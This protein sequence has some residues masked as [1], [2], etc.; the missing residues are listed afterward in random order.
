[1][2][3]I[4]FNNILPLVIVC[5]L[6]V[7]GLSNG[8]LP[9]KDP[10]GI[11]GERVKNF[12]TNIRFEESSEL[13]GINH[14][15]EIYDPAVDFEQL[16]PYHANSAGVAV[17]DIDN[18]GFQDIFF[19]TMKN[20]KSNYLYKNIK[21]RSFIDVTKESGLFIDTND[22]GA[23]T[24]AVFFDY[25]NDSCQDLFIARI[26]CHSLYRGNC[27]GQFSDVSEKT[28]VAKYC[29]FAVGVNLV[30]Y[31]NDG[32]TDLYIPN[33]NGGE[34]KIAR[35][36]YRLITETSN[37]QDGGGENIL[38]ENQGVKGFVDVAKERGVADPGLS[39]ASGWSDF[40]KDGKADLYVADDFSRDQF[41]IGEEESNDFKNISSYIFKPEIRSRGSMTV[42]IGDIDNDLRPDVFTTNITRVGYD[43]GLNYMWLNKKKGKHNMIL[44]NQA[45]RLQLSKCGWGWGARFIDADLDGRLE[46]VVNNGFWDDGPKPYWY[47][48]NTWLSL[49][50]FL[51]KH[52]TNQPKVRGSHMANKEP[53]CFFKKME[54]TYIDI[55]ENTGIT[56]LKNGR[57]MAT[58]D[59]NNDGKND[60]IIA[61]FLDKPS[62]YVNKTET[63]NFW[64]GFKLTGS[65]SN[66]DAVGAKVLVFTNSRLKQIRELYPANGLSGEN[67]KRLLFGL[68]NSKRAKVKIIWPNGKDED[69][70]LLEGNQYYDIKE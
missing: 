24:A 26:G 13:L 62:F 5:I 59:F 60:F 52:N 34:P 21:G 6:V 15:H 57:G 45:P 33:F 35:N 19:T 22:P 36:F 44:V 51:R 7:A 47:T 67:D 68:G 58:L 43:I 18:D 30:D 40:N 55:A 69:L 39:W 46:L 48:W 11:F 25:D 32:Y 16:Y 1:M 49:P 66:R 64:I 20:G 2:K 12:Q 28:G 29:S 42:E 53:N 37:N 9:V 38:L 41:F 27:K 4:K 70:G 56:D 3:K 23:A 8:A 10:F 54:S 17:G 31:N 61:N 65:V 63:K 50:S 14:L